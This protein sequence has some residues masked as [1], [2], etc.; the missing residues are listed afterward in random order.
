MLPF[1]VQQEDLSS[2]SGAAKRRR[3]NALPRG[4]FVFEG[5][6]NMISGAF[7]VTDCTAMENETDVVYWKCERLVLLA[8]PLVVPASDSEWKSGMGHLRGEVEVKLRM[9]SALVGGTLNSHVTEVAASTW[10][11]WPCDNAILRALSSNGGQ[12]ATFT[13]PGKLSRVVGVQPDIVR[14]TRLGKRLR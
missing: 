1:V 14:R 8:K 13:S 10:L 4:F 6:T 3:K 5:A 2:T 11:C 7:I 9:D 12:A